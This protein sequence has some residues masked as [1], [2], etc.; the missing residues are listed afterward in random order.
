MKTKA[1]LV[2]STSFKANADPTSRTFEGLAAT[3]EK[4][5]GND[6]IEKGAFKDTLKLW[7]SGSEA[8]PLLNSHDQYDIF[9][10]IGQL[11][12]AKETDAG[13][14]TKWEVIDGAEGDGVLARLR[15]SKTTGKP[16]V[17]KM[18][19][20]Y[21]PIEYSYEQPPGT[22]SFWDKIRHLTKVDLEEVSLVLF[23]MNEGASIDASTVKS[24]LI[25][26]KSTDPRKL[27]IQTKTELRKLASRIGVLLKNKEVAPPAT[28]GD[29][30]DADE[31]DEQ[32]EVPTPT[33]AP[34]PSGDRTDEDDAEDLE[35]SGEEEEKDKK[36]KTGTKD[37]AVGCTNDVCPQNRQG[38]ATACSNGDCPMKSGKSVYRYGDALT[39][40]L[41]KTLL[42]NK[43][44]GIGEK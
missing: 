18:S 21:M 6:I 35:G 31:Q 24:F 32:E 11:V 26:T 13:L 44:S 8:I 16:I 17:G 33:P 4:D 29:E 10:A 20:G 15:P 42:K 22:E 14:W 36:K 12:D 19:I 2:V 37:S 5:L 39:Q 43:V 34:A 9:S 7:K 1:R 27:S 30:D 23:P 28:D 40:R 41:Q 38:D 3:W 25:S